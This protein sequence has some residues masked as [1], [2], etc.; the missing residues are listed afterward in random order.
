M[1]EKAYR[2]S[3][4]TG[5]KFNLKLQCRT[6]SDRLIWGHIVG[7]PEHVDG[8]CVKMKGT[9]QN[10]T[11][12]KKIESQL[13]QAQKMEAVGRLAGGVAHDFNNMLSV[14]LGNAEILLED[15][16]PD[17]PLTANVQ[18]IHRATPALRRPHPSTAG[19]CKKRQT[20]A[21]RVLDINQVVGEMLKMLRRLI[22][23]DIELAWLPGQGV[24]PVRMDPSQVDQLLANLCI[25]A[26]D[27]I[28]DIGRVTIETDNII[29]NADYCRD[30][31]GFHPGKYIMIVVS[32]TGSGMDR[33]T[34]AN[35][36]EPFFTTKSTD[37]GSGLGLATVI[38][39][40]KQNNGFINVYSELG[41]GSTFK[42]YLPALGEEVVPEQK[43]DTGLPPRTGPRNPPAGGR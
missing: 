31:L 2:L 3:M 36:F 24:W 6:A 20:I 16:P 42:L 29:F 37:R 4:E 22:G 23:E 38:G 21:P 9:F 10:I 28:T 32:D 33:E 30:H 39:I 12:Q 15:M 18:E 13:H 19:L 27:A 40:V 1:L 26:R 41:K 34:R 35:L 5:E 8:K 11:E 17:N 7:R 14:I 43:E 25:N